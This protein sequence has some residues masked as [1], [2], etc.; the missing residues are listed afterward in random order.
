M[1]KDKF[2]N[3]LSGAVQLFKVARY[4]SPTKVSE[5]KP[6]SSDLD[7]L[8]VFPFLNSE[9]TE[10]LKSE[11]S[12]YLA[13][14]EDVSPQIDPLEWWKRHNTNLPMWASACCKVALIQPSST[15]AEHFFFLFLLVHLANSRNLP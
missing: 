13:A 8:S 9:A 1:L 2:N 14:A 6:A 15:A 5:L 11:L 3:D 7:S 10:G 4:F 12:N